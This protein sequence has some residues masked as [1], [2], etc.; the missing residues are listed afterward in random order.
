MGPAWEFS[1]LVFVEPPS[2]SVRVEGIW[3]S[4]TLLNWLCVFFFF[5]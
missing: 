2:L 3:M 4:A 5:F 1:E